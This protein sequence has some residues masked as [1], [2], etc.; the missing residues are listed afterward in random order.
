M[1]KRIFYFGIVISFFL[2]SCTKDA[3]F[4]SKPYPIIQTQNVTQI[5]SSGATFNGDF[6]DLGYSPILEYGFVFSIDEPSLENSDSLIVNMNASVGEFSQSISEK[7]AG[8]IAYNVKAYAKTDSNIIYG[9]NV[10]F[11]SQGSTYNP[12]DFLFQFHI[13]GWGFL[14]GN[15]NNEVGFI[16]FPSEDFYLIYPDINLVI[17]KQNIP[18]DGNSG[19]VYASFCLDNYLYVLT[20]HSTK[21]LQYNVENDQWV[22]LGPRPFGPNAITGFF[23]FSIDNIGYFLGRENFYSYNQSTDTWTK[24]SDLPSNYIFA[25]EVIDNKVYV[26][27]DNNKIWVFDPGLNTWVQESEYPG[28]WKGEIISLSDSENLYLGLSYYEYSSY[29]DASQD[30]WRY[31]INTKTWERIDDF[32]IKHSQKDLFTFKIGDFRYV[33]YRISMYDYNV[34]TFSGVENAD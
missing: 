4:I 11:L 7:L 14:H 28:E 8:N 32:P 3:E 6:I 29:G 33:G 16:L 30:F 10:E 13:Y 12:W 17:K 21:V 25:A 22:M 9:N 18:I 2:V 20:N 24:L 31:S 5:D 1:S 27:A 19:T 26:L 15:S 23:G 34:W